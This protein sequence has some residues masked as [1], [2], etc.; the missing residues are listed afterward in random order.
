MKLREASGILCYKISIK[1]KSKL[2]KI[3]VVRPVMFY[4]S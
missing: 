2:Y 1:L 3:A 4:G